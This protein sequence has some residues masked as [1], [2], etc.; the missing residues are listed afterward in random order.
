MSEAGKEARKK[1]DWRHKEKL[2]EADN[3]DMDR[4][5]CHEDEDAVVARG[6]DWEGYWRRGQERNKAVNGT[7][8][9]N[10]LPTKRDAGIANWVAADGSAVEAE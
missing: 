4:R 7:R 8:S 2:E 3:E 6:K 10:G 5:L 1:R 9:W